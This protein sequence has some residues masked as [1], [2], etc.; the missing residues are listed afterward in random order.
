LG[1]PSQVA[2][3]RGFETALDALRT[4][5]QDCRGNNSRR[6]GRLS[7]QQEADSEFWRPAC[8]AVSTSTYSSTTRIPSA[9]AYSR[10]S[11]SWAGMEKPSFSCSLEETRAYTTPSRSREAPVV[12]V[13]RSRLIVSSGEIRLITDRP[14][15]E[16]PVQV[17]SEIRCASPLTPE[18]A[19]RFR[20]TPYAWPPD[21]SGPPPRPC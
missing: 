13:V 10:S 7:L 21:L 17:P 20:P 1:C 8:L 18:S 2:G 11:L 12:L 6:S 9:S 4:V 15:V 3:S 14:L 5:T 16:R 19:S